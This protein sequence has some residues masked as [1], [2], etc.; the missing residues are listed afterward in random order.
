MGYYILL[1]EKR[2]FMTLLMSLRKHMNVRIV[3]LH[4]RRPRQQQR[5]AVWYLHRKLFAKL[6]I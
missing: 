1:L 5:C 6:Y 3:D 4:A 2:S